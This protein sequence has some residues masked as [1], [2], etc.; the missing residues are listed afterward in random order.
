MKLKTQKTFFNFLVKTL[1]Y[2][3][4]VILIDDLNF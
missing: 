2:N 1:K 4:D 3:Q